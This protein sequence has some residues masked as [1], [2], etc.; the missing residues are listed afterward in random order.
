VKRSKRIGSPSG[1]VTL[2][3]DFGSADGYVGALKGVLLARFE[4]ARIVDLAHDVAPGDVASASDVLARAAPHF[5]PRTVHV[6]VVDPGVGTARRGL[7]LLLEQQLYVGPDNGIF[8]G[9]LELGGEPSA[10]ALENWGLWREPVSPVFHGRDVFAP[11]GAHLA[12]G[13]DLREVGPALEPAS[14]VRLTR[15]EPSAEGGAL[16]GEVVHVDRFGN[17]VTN[18]RLP[19]G[20]PAASVELAGRTLALSLTYGDAA[21]GEL[22]AL[23]GSTGRVEIAVNGGSAAA[24]L[25]GRA[26]LVV[27][28]RAP[29]EPA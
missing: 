28:L 6:A 7:A 24:R 3:T 4:P 17:L 10:F 12:S 23:V 9:V 18:L 21:P 29:R 14:L 1:I 13:G 2:T 15:P 20:A 16:R 22:V 19:E 5:P 11:V 8:S 25:E 27:T 26:G